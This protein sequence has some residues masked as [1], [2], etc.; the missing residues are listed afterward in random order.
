M[1]THVRIPEHALQEMEHHAS[2]AYPEE[3]CGVLI[4]RAEGELRTV[5]RAEPL[6]NRVAVRRERRFVI[7]AADLLRVERRLEGTATEVLGFYHSHPDHPPRPSEFDRDH[8]WPWYVYVILGVANGQPNG[9]AAFELEA[10]S[11][12]FHEIAV[13]SEIDPPVASSNGR[14][15]ESS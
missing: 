9:A 14:V 10:D 1:I 7:D 13:V 12:R 8:A 6:A 3:G 15:S 2:E 5:L 11:G 4:G